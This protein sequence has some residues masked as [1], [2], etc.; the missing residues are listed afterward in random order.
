MTTQSVC[1]YLS[2]VKY[3]HV[4]MGFNF[5]FYEAPELKLTLRDLIVWLN[6]H[7][8]VLRL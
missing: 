4:S 5:P 3:L 8:R 1:N 6:M 7:L 2:G